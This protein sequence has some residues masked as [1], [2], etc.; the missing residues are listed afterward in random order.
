[1][2]ENIIIRE[3]KLEDAC[4]IAMLKLQ[5]WLHTYATDGIEG[6]YADY[7]DSEITKEKTEGI[8]LNPEKK[9]FLAEKEGRIIGCY[10]LDFDTK[11]PIEGIKA[12]ELTVLYLSA[13]FHG[14]GIGRSMLR[15]A[16]SELIVLGHKAV[17]L[18][19]YHQ[20]LQAIEF[21]QRQTYELKG[22]CYFE[23]GDS[24][25]ENWLFWKKLVRE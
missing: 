25:Y 16:E 10:Q 21:Y 20:N 7:L 22:K 2:T 9:L 11:C 17:W 15:H 4:R 24:K 1:M 23:M 6:E 12:P 19:A 13:H 8:I 18:T 3:A 5:V 14:K